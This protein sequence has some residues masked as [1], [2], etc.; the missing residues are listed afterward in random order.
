MYDEE[1]SDRA[2]YAASKRIGFKLQRFSEDQSLSTAR[3]LQ[4]LIDPDTGQPARSFTDRERK[5]MLNEQLVCRFDYTYFANRYIWIVDKNG[6]LVQFH[7]N[8]AQLLLLYI[9]AEH[10][11]KGISKEFINNKARQLGVTTFFETV[12]VH[13]VQFYPNTTALV[14]SASEDNSEQMSFMADLMWKKMP[15]YLMPQATSRRVGR[16]TRF[17]G[18]NSQLIVRWLNQKGDIGRGQTPILAHITEAAYCEDPD[19]KLDSGLFRAMHTG[20]NLLLCMESTARIKEDWWHKQ[21]KLAETGWKAGRSRFRPIFLPYFIADDMYPTKG[22]IKSHPVPV[23]WRPA[24]LTI[25]HA[26][27]AEAYA[28]ESDLLRAILGL[29]WRM[30]RE[31]MWFWETE[32]EEAKSKGSLNKFYREMCA[33]AD[34]SFQLASAGVFDV[35]TISFYRERSR[36]PIHVWGIKGRNKEI[37]PRHWP[38]AWEVDHSGDATPSVVTCPNNSTFDLIP[39]RYNEETDPNNKLL[40]FEDPEPGAEYGIGAD[41]GKGIG[42]DATVFQVM[43]KGTFSRG[44]K[45]VAEWSSNACN[46]TEAIPFAYAIGSLYTVYREGGPVQPK[47]VIEVMDQGRTLQTALSEM[48]FGNMHIAETYNRYQKEFSDNPA[49]GFTANAQTRE[50]ALSYFIRVVRDYG[51]EIDSRWLIDELSSL[52]GIVSATGRSVRIEHAK[53]QHDDRVIA[54]AIVYMSLHRDQEFSQRPAT[55]GWAKQYLPLDDDERYSTFTGDEQSSSSAI[56]ENMRSY[57]ARYLGGGPPSRNR[58]SDIDYAG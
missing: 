5:F 6:D 4:K 38:D 30:S 13:G 28:K 24:E 48:G 27:R 44:P 20:P 32:R 7:P 57:M 21:W 52:T 1:L 33:S 40:V 35:E 3:K 2:I 22:W 37:H 17:E 34:E 58:D 26:A 10:Q 50:M 18:M 42:Q 29:G 8:R 12:I 23:D 36:S 47:W 55:F 14:A 9:L 54:A 46:A 43:K 15:F 39:L 16:L 45:L 51:I 11:H 53:N 25:R 56:S 49:V 31:Q 19:N 41:T